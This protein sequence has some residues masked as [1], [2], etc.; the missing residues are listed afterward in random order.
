MF[1]AE[2]TVTKRHLGG[3]MVAAGI[4]ALAVIAGLEIV[5]SDA[6]SFGT[7]QKIGVVLSAA[8]LLIGLTLLPLGRQPV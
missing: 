8:S 7:L 3:L 2:F 1:R 4:G 5:R 6:G